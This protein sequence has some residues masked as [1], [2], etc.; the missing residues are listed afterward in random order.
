METLAKKAGKY[1]LGELH[2]SLVLFAN[3]SEAVQR[4]LYNL[5]FPIPASLPRVASPVHSIV[6]CLGRLPGLYSEKFYTL[7]V[8]YYIV[9]GLSPC[10][11]V[12]DGFTCLHV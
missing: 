3:I 9:T 8:T 11:H 5:S 7:K 6:T 12:S 10:S 2:Y 4:T 1:Y